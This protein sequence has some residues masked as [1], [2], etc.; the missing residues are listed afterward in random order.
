MHTRTLLTAIATA[1]I[2]AIVT[3]SLSSAQTTPPKTPPKTTTST[4]EV[5]LT[6]SFGSLMSAINA[7]SS[8]SDSIKAMTNVSA[9]N[10]QLVNVDDLL[11]GNDEQ[12]LKNALEKNEDGVEALRKTLGADSTISNV[13]T[14]GGSANA[15]T[16]TS[17]T[18]STTTSSTPSTPLTTKDIVAADVTPDGKVVLYYWKKA[19]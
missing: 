8:R 7:A 15:T 14:T 9:A 2:A 1:A 19:S 12:A 3:P 10:V 5:A 11:K 13:I 17:T 6:P 4:G 16:S 18:T